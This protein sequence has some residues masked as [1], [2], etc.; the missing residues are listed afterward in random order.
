M[1]NIDEKEKM[2]KENNENS[3][4][5][6]IMNDEDRKEEEIKKLFQQN[7]KK[8]NKEKI[9][10]NE[11]DNILLIKEKVQKIR[12]MKLNSDD[13]LKNKKYEEAIDKYKETINELLDEIGNFSLDLKQLFQIR[14]EIIIPCYLNISLCNMKL[15]RWI[16][17]K[18]YS[19]K[20]L[21][22]NQENI[23]ASYRLCLA[24]IK[25]GHLKK[26][27]YQL[28]EL[29]KL[30]GGTPELEE[31]EKIYEVNKLN[32]E[33]NNGEF[34]RKMGRK[35]KT[36]KIN[37]YED[38]KTKIEIEKEKTDNANIGYIKKIKN[39]LYGFISSCCKKRKI[40][41]KNKIK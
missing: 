27:D 22:L 11:I 13:L 21:E 4:D 9:K 38:K 25:L 35:L 19:K 40:K 17:V 33:G 41:K 36:G 6:E 34:L 29:E 5:E 24:N 31:L 12:N 2:I 3:S 10:T 30:I 7:N 32:A 37:M 1:S 28:E 14:E 16:K 15:N 26:A 20:V 8:E 18:T 23:K 39:Y